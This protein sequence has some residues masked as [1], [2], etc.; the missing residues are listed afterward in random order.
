MTTYTAGQ[1]HLQCGAFQKQFKL[2]W[3]QRS[4]VDKTDTPYVLVAG[5]PG[6]GKTTVLLCKGLQWL[7]EGRDVL[8]CTIHSDSVPTSWYLYTVLS[9][10]RKARDDARSPE[11]AEWGQVRYQSFVLAEAQA[12]QDAVDR[13]AGFVSS[14]S[15]AAFLFDYMAPETPELCCLGLDFL[16]ELRDRFPQA[17][18]WTSDWFSTVPDGFFLQHLH[19]PVR[20]TK[21]IFPLINVPVEALEY[22]NK[23]PGLYTYVNRD[24]IA[25]GPDVIHLRHKGRRGDAKWPLYSHKCGRRVAKVLRQIGVGATAPKGAG[26][27]GDDGASKGEHRYQF[28]D[29]LV[30]TR[31]EVK[32]ADTPAFVQGLQA[33][34]IPAAV[35]GKGGN[36][37]TEE[38]LSDV[39]LAPEDKVTVMNYQSCI[40]LDRQVVVCL[41]GAGQDETWELTEEEEEQIDTNQFPAGT[42]N[43][44]TTTLTIT[45]DMNK[46]QRKTFRQKLLHAHRS[47][48]ELVHRLTLWTRCCRQLIV[49][50]LPEQVEGA[51]DF[52]MHNDSR[53]AVM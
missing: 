28:R 15:P 8:V 30:V 12:V 51:R 14:S 11:D 39:I 18:I 3:T 6:T 40:G 2:T 50:H 21:E 19:T 1:V 44:E 45:L 38:A 29:V 53:C 48:S 25:T 37:T 7:E 35:F 5:A 13:V 16:K 49:V 42:V 47:E 52:R 34:G 41:T 27:K 10:A 46:E 32:A 4:T 26:V 20:F 36:V 24:V 43:T 33:A 17:P 9:Q 23:L 31:N 22:V